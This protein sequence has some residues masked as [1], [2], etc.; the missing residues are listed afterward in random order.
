MEARVKSR[1]GRDRAN[2]KSEGQLLARGCWLGG[3][4]SRVRPRKPCRRLCRRGQADEVHLPV[5]ERNTE[6]LAGRTVIKSLEVNAVSTP[7]TF[8]YQRYGP[9]PEP[10]HPDRRMQFLDTRTGSQALSFE[11]A[12][13]K[14]E[15][16]DRQYVG[17][18]R[19]RIPAQHRAGRRHVYFDAQGQGCPSMPACL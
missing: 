14:Q 3:S 18:R 4:R 8:P 16:K 17:R 2:W 9:L 12:N 10:L 1:F 11:R 19:A 7:G 5:I 15:N 13:P 6:R